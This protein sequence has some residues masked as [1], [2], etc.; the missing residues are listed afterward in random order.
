MILPF[1]SWFASIFQVSNVDREVLQL[2]ILKQ[3]W[4]CYTAPCKQSRIFPFPSDPFFFFSPLNQWEKYTLKF[5]LKMGIKRQKKIY[6][7]SNHKLYQAAIRFL[8]WSSFVLPIIIPTLTNWLKKCTNSLKQ[9]IGTAYFLNP[10]QLV[11][12]FNYLCVV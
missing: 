8:F 6:T 4:V 9:S 1:I 12:H 5:T 2:K 7:G 11:P 10:L 3:I